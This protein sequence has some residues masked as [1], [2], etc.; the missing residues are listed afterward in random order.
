MFTVYKIVTFS[1]LHSEYY[2][3]NK[4]YRPAAA[5]QV[6]KKKKKKVLATKPEDLNLLPGAQ[7]V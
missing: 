1:I 7:V 3:K 5:H 2:L 6:K 4:K